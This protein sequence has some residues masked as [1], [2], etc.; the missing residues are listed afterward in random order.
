MSTA[1]R[2]TVAH[3]NQLIAA[4]TMVSTLACNK[5][6]STSG[7]YAVVDPMPSP[8]RCLGVAYSIKATAVL[9][10]GVITLDMSDPATTGAAFQ[11]TD[12]GL[13]D[14]SIGNGTLVSQTRT[15]SGLRVLVT[16]SPGV[17]AVTVNV[18]VS[19]AAGPGT[20][21][22]NVMWGTNPDG[23]TDVTVNLSEY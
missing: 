15:A 12:A 8:A 2:S 9:S 7:G 13:V 20:V 10:K 11:T 16:P 19:C 18:S 5:C 21:V 1:R 14:L 22:A 17:G 4:A 23:G 6:N 3:M